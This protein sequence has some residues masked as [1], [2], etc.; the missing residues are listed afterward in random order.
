MHQR[1]EHVLDAELE[2]IGEDMRALAGLIPYRESF[3]SQLRDRLVS[4]AASTD[5]N[6][7]STREG[8]GIFAASLFLRY[9]RSTVSLRRGLALAAL[10]TVLLV[11]GTLAFVPTVRAQVGEMLNVW[12]RLELGAVKVEVGGTPPGFTPLRPAYLPEAF[13]NFGG[14][15][16]AQEGVRLFFGNPDGEWLIVDQGRASADRPLPDGKRVV[17][18]GQE[19]TL[20]ANQ[21]GTAEVPPPSDSSAVRPSGWRAMRYENATRVIWHFRETRVEILSNLPEQEILKVARSMNQASE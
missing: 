10:G 5:G 3:R 6:G 14:V 18:N 15:T 21:T 16:V 2:S 20:L 17:V 19:G 11:L 4:L 1:D 8:E 12:L 7:R 13:S 9:L